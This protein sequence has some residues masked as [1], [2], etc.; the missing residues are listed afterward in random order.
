M[1]S[2]WRRAGAY[3]VDLAIGFIIFCIPMAFISVSIT[4]T[5]PCYQQ[6]YYCRYSQAVTLVMGVVYQLVLLAYFSILE[7]KV[8]YTIGERLFSLRLVGKKNLKST[9]VRNLTKTILNSLLLIDAIGILIYGI[10]FTE[11][12]AGNKLIGGKRSG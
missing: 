1:V 8:G 7:S 4:Q 9:V 11:K 6:T 5:R 10:R 3:I 2:L 12:I